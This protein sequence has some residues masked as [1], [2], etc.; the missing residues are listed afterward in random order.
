MALFLPSQGTLTTSCGSVCS[1]EFHA[2]NMEAGAFGP[3]RCDCREIDTWSNWSN[4]VSRCCAVFRVSQGRGTITFITNDQYTGE[5][6]D[7]LFSTVGLGVCKNRTVNLPSQDLQDSMFNGLG[8]YT[9]LCSETRELKCSNDHQ[10]TS[11]MRGGP[12]VLLSPV[13]LRTMSAARQSFL[14]GRPGKV[15]CLL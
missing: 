7:M 12:P 8:C 5:F 14:D 1:G 9:C 11:I 13:S 10:T 6:K 15:C 2:G 4:C 3:W